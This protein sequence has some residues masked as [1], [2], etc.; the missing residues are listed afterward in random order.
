[1][2]LKTSRHIQQGARGSGVG[3]LVRF[4]A[5]V[6]CASMLRVPRSQRCCVLQPALVLVARALAVVIVGAVLRPLRDRKPCPAT[7]NVAGGV[8]LF[9]VP[10]AL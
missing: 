3:T 7:C 4:A 1:M 9:V 10:D 8:A 5:A 6:R 2:K